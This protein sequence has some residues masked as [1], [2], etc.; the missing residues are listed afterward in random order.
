MVSELLI[1]FFRVEGLL[2]TYT[3][4]FTYMVLFTYT[5]LF[6]YMALFIDTVLFTRNGGS[7]LRILQCKVENSGVSKAT[8]WFCTCLGK[9]CHKSD[10]SLRS[11]GF[12]W[13]RCEPSSLSCELSWCAYSHIFTTIRGDTLVCVHYLSTKWR[14]NMK[15]R[16]LTEIIFRCGK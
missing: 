10:K 16:S 9:F 4:L 1:V 11:L 6:T 14:Q 8:V 5:V 7:D 13:D 3:V 15:L 12:K 2:F